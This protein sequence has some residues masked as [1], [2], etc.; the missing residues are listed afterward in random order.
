[1]ESWREFRT[2]F[3]TVAQKEDRKIILAWDEYEN[4]HRLL[5]KENEDGQRLLEAM[6]SFS[7]HQN[8]VIFLFTG[9]LLFADL[10]GEPDFSRYFVHAHRLKVDYLKKEAVEKLITKPYE[11]FNLIYPPETVE[12]I[13]QRTCGHPALLQHICFEL[14]NIANIQNRKEMKPEDLETV[15]REKILDRGNAVMTTFW[16]DFCT[17]TLKTTVMEIMQKQTSANRSD[18]VRLLDYGFIKEE[19]AG[20]YRLRVSLFEQWIAKYGESFR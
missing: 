6:R 14:V 20:K 12:E 15:C 4:F 9:L 1:M 8:Q 3:E 13:W 11:E 2:F 10:P 7:Q 17:G 19:E 5:Q 16:K 18:V